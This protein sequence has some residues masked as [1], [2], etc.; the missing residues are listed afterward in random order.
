[1]LE[2]I[3]GAIYLDQGFDAVFQVIKNIIFTSDKV[4]P[5]TKDPKSKL[6]E[7]IQQHLSITPTYTVLDETGK[8]HEKIFTIIASV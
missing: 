8:D 5:E 3:L 2:A 4:R 6:Q 7:I 1:M